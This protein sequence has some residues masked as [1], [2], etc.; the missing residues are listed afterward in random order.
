MIQSWSYNALANFQQNIHQTLPPETVFVCNS[1]ILFEI[2]GTH[3]N[4]VIEFYNQIP[5]VSTLGY[6]HRYVVYY[7]KQNCRHSVL[8]IN[9]NL[10]HIFLKTSQ[11]LHLPTSQVALDL[12]IDCGVWWNSHLS[13]TKRWTTRSFLECLDCHLN[14]VLLSN[15]WF[16]HPYIYLEMC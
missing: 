14:V 16:L 11:H 13:R 1:L 8:V 3:K 7:Y 2:V 10:L 9:D 15:Q 4:I 6:I 12:Y 5:C